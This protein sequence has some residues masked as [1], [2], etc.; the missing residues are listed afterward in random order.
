MGF[1]DGVGKILSNAP[2][3]ALSMIPG[4]SQYLG[5][6]EANAANAQQAADQTAFQDVC[7][8]QLTKENQ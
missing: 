3:I 5:Q 4:I 2:N 8:I 1:F 7:Q 6:S